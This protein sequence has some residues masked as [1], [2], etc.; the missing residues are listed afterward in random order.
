MPGKLR[1][2][3]AFGAFTKKREAVSAERKHPGS[4]VR[5]TSIRGKR[6]YLVLKS[7]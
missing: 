4:F 5:K 2:F 1:K 6:R 7:K 3:F